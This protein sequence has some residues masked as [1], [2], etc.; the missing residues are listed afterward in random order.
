MTTPDHRR[1]GRLALPLGM[2][3]LTLCFLYLGIS[4]WQQH[5]QAWHNQQSRGLEYALHDLH[6]EQEA[7]RL[8][9]L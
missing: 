4:A 7:L 5:D 3:L 1:N 8:Q 2:L 6:Q 9:A